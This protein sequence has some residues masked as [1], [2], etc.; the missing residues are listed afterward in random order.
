MKAKTIRCLAAIIA[1]SLAANAALG[2]NAAEV[3][4]LAK[5]GVSEDVATAYVKNQSSPFH[6]SSDDILALKAQGVSSG[7]IAA[8]LDHDTRMQSQAQTYRPPPPAQPAP[9]YP[10]IQA[11]PVYSQPAPTTYYP[12]EVIPASPGSDYYWWPGYWDNG[13]WIGGSWVYGWPWWG[14]GWGW[15][16]G[17]P[18]G[19]GWG[20]YGRGYYGG[21]GRG[22]Y[23]GYRGGFG[24][25]RG[26]IGGFRGGIG[27]GRVGGIGGG[28]A[29]GF[30]GGHGGGGHR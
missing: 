16:W 1:T 23:G 11:A 26:G 24:G 29:G 22:Y 13:I 19:Y 17:W 14:Y 30:G 7:V 21:Y 4:K 9:V 12:Q 6:L 20:G 8:M 5:S 25:Y 28:H 15:G 3:V 27:S 18:R 2:P 10:P